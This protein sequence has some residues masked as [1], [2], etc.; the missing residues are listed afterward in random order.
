VGGS[1][2]AY[3]L[4]MHLRTAR[5]DMKRSGLPLPRYRVGAGWY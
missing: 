2:R 3:L 5:Q 4:L 1:R